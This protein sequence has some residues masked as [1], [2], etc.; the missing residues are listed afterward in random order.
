MIS[1]GFQELGM[2]FVTSTGKDKHNKIQNNNE[3]S[4]ALNTITV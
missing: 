2:N 3:H 1:T 4:K